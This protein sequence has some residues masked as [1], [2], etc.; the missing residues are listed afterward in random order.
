[1][2]KTPIVPL[3]VLEEH[4]E[5]FFI[6]HY[7]YFKELINPF[8]NTV[9]HVD[10]HEDLVLPRLNSSIDEL[11]DDLGKIYA[12][13]YQELGIASFLI[14]LIYKGL[15][16]NYTFLGRHDGYSGQR[17]NRYVASY[18][19]EGK[20]FKTGPVNDFLRLQLQSTE[21]PWGNYSFFSYQEIGLTSRFVTSQPLILDIDLDYF[22]CDN[23]LSSAQ[24][25]IEI[26][27]EAYL[28]FINNRY[29]PFRIMPV[30]ALSTKKVADRYYLRY[31]EW[32]ELPDLKK[33]S[34]DV[35]DRRINRFISFLKQNN[36]KPRLIDICRSRL[37]GYTPIDQWQ[38]IE[39]RLIAGLSEI[40]NLE[41]CHISEFEKSY[42]GQDVSSH[43]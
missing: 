21:N 6:W 14:P 15:I 1:M 4:H 13:G 26:T 34:F 18:K 32:Q 9:L 33:V 2:T 23:S 27:E 24:P 12:Y 31:N 43:Y 30:A 5:A 29:H 11:A 7:G 16:N 10:S 35:I 37:S 3:F 25:E 20:F 8:G 28:S 40:Y 36:V 41:I 19:S 39:D 17:S 22:S 38:Y 42:G